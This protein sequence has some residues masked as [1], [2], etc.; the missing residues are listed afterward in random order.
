[1]SPEF[2]FDGVDIVVNRNSLR[3]LLDFC[4]GRVKGSFRLNL[5]LVKNTLFVERCERN[6][7]EM[8]RGLRFPDGAGI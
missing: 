4:N 1:M 6:A 3:K 7:T 2:C 5:L 8:I